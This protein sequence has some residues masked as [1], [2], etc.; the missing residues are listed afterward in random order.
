[1]NSGPV[2]TQS[3]TDS[4]NTLNLP[5]LYHAVHSRRRTTPNR[6]RKRRRY[7]SRHKRS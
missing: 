1:M 5:Q 3:N 7:F 4:Q 2:A 6:K